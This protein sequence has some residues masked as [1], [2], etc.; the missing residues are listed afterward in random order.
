MAGQAISIA[1]LADARNAVAGLKDTGAAADTMSN[2]LKEADRDV[3]AIGDRMGDGA[4]KSSQFVGGI[5]DIGGALA[6]MGGPLGAVGSGMETMTPALMGMV[7]AF[8]LAELA[9]NSTALA[10]L[11]NAA[12]TVASKTAMIATSAATKAAAAAQ[13][14]LNVAM[15]ANPIGLIIAGVLLLIVTIGLMVKHWDKIK[16]FLLATWNVIKSAFSATWDW[17]KGAFAATMQAIA[18]VGIAV[19]NGIKSFFRG[20]FNFI[21]GLFS[22]FVVGVKAIW[23]GITWLYTKAVEVGGTVVGWFKGLPGK[24]VAAV[25]NVL[26]T[27]KAKGRDLLSGI[28]NGVSEGWNT[29]KTWFSGLGSKVIS[30]VG[31]LGSTLYNVGEKIIQGLIDGIASMFGSVKSTLGDLTSKIADWKGPLSTDKNLLVGAGK[32]IMGGL[33]NGIESQTG[34][35]R[36]TLKDVTGQIPTGIDP[37]IG[38]GGTLRVERVQAISAGGRGSG[39][40]TYNI[41]VE[42][43]PTADKAEIGR[44]VV[45]AIRA[46]EAQTARTVLV[47]P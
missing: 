16:A 22:T 29:V 9:A 27:L 46:H 34:K 11:K 47:T 23:S 21:K 31:N 13:W 8:D 15:N 14:L 6:E 43:P 42:V 40:N 19:W 28:S 44:A 1:I 10:W 37:Q 25:G 41:N 36:N 4:S 7:G 45:D 33:I 20:A 24:L 5:G 26:N 18:A 17:I 2:K 12:S 39:G 30:A 35:L 32:A 3:K 38:A